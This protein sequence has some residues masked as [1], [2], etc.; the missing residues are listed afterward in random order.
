M[1]KII[2]LVLLLCIFACSRKEAV[3]APSKEITIPVKGIQVLDNINPQN[4]SIC[5]LSTTEMSKDCVSAYTA[6]N[7]LFGGENISP[8]DSYTIIPNVGVASVIKALKFNDG[9]NTYAFYFIKLNLFDEM[10]RIT[11]CKTCQPLLGF[12][13]Y[14]YEHRWTPWM[15]NNNI[16]SYG[17]Q[18]NINLSQLKNGEQALELKLISPENFLL[19]IAGEREDVPGVRFGY[20]DIF[21]LGNRRFGKPIE[22]LGDIDTSYAN[23]SRSLTDQQDWSG[24]ITYEFKAN[25]DIP[26]VH[27]TKIMKQTCSDENLST[28]K[29]STNAIQVIDYE[30]DWKISKKYLRVE[31][32]PTKANLG[33]Q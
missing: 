14:K 26:L 23:C 10:N 12:V 5:E 9:L 31:K 6:F 8:D 4:F 29:I 24:K 28:K 3:E 25:T 19:S 11:F 30:Y 16:G 2:S 20:T 13:G 15:M 21:I 22:Y 17:S 1:K 7:D 32:T 33:S 27:V 18:G